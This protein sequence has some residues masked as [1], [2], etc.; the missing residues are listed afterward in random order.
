[1]EWPI[2]TMKDIYHVGTLDKTHKRMNSH[3]GDGLSIS[4]HPS[5]WERINPLTSGT[6]YECRKEKN[7]FLDKHAL[8]DHQLDRIIAWGLDK[9]WIEPCPYYRVTRWD[10]EW[11]ETY[12][13]HFSTKAEAVSEAEEEGEVS[14]AADGFKMTKTMQQKTHSSEQDLD[15]LCKL[16]VLYSEY[17]LNIDGVWWD[18]MLAPYQYSA[19]RGVIVPSRL[20]EWEMKAIEEQSF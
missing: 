20:S 1:M 3:E 6:T 14:Y 19:P 11:E 2:R 8:T 5:A 18:D 4:T 13:M 10:S 12:W 15:P 7:Q 16:I 17:A 9:N